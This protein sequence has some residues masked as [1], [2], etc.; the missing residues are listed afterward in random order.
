[1]LIAGS[2]V[3]YGLH[4]VDKVLNQSKYA[5][6]KAFRRAYYRFVAFSL[7][8]IPP[9]NNIIVWKLHTFKQYNKLYDKD[10]YHINKQ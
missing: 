1:M 2:K 8:F 10:I 4:R 6:N 3:S 7:S 9:N 5:K